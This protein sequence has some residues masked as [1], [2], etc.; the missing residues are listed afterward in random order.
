MRKRVQRAKFV[1]FDG[2]SNLIVC[3]NAGTI[4]PSEVSPIN[5]TRTQAFVI[6]TGTVDADGDTIDPK[7]WNLER[8]TKNPIVL[9]GHD[10]MLPIGHALKTWIEPKA[11]KSLGWFPTAD[12][13]EFADNVFKMIQAKIL[14]ATSVGFKPTE[15]TPSTRSPVGFFPSMDFS[16]Q[17]LLEWSVVSIPNNPD[18]LATEK[19][20]RGI[21]WKLYHN[22][23]ERTLDEDLGLI[24]TKDLER[25]Y[26]VTKSLCARSAS[27]KGEKMA[28]E[29]AGHA[30]SKANEK[31][32]KEAMD[33]HKKAMESHGDML[34]CHKEMKEH[35][36]KCMT[37]MKAVAD[38]AKPPVD[39]TDN[40]EDDPSNSGEGE[41]DSGE[42]VTP[43]GEGG[44]KPGDTSATDPSED[45]DETDEG[46]K[47]GKKKKPS[48]DDADD[49]S[50]EKNLRA[51]IRSALT[52]EKGF[53]GGDVKAA[54]DQVVKLAVEKELRRMRGQE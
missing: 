24:A 8:Y 35:L 2:T 43:E 40:D 10:P 51:A 42:I 23:I 46:T 29:K 41:K 25:T 12:V 28:V 53:E 39:D 37:A 27:K 11:L 4:I 48:E 38:A 13:S 54:L 22:Y 15:F 14:I 26:V 6:S 36:N 47:K 19:N 45:Q 20:I 31:K 50:E 52:V 30:L 9:F 17:E 49:D 16:K 33:F 5:D 18:T 21:D 44:G 32:L 3:K 34:K 1:D 7:G